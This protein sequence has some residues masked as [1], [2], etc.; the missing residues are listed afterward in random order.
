VWNHGA[1]SDDVQQ[2]PGV[3]S[4]PS[5]AS[6]YLVAVGRAVARL[7]PGG[8][9]ALVTGAGRFARFARHGLE[10]AAPDIGLDITA[11]LALDEEPASIAAARGDAI[12]LCGP[13]EGEVALLRALRARA[14]ADVLLAGVSPGVSDFAK[15]LGG[16]PEDM[17]APVQWHF[18]R[19][20]SSPLGPSQ[21]E[22]LGDA[23]E[24]GA[25]EIDYVAAQ[26]YAAAV[27]ADRCTALS[28]AAPGLAAASLRTT[29]FFGDFELDP[30]TGLQRGHRLS[31]VHWRGGRRE[32][33]LTDAA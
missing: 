20:G 11:R 33:F 19:P 30:R 8:R 22:L 16:D 18:E 17:L 7:R 1:A 3:V 29:T 15:L 25:G 4:V 24:A 12:V 10:Q 28:P 32:L 14:G 9:V 31:V 13:L 26:A 27:I 23:R 6:R 2:L 21:Q 5:P